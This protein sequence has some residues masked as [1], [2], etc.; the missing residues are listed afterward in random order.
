MNTS[1]RNLRFDSDR[2]GSII[3][4]VVMVLAV[5]AF[6]TLAYF[7]VTTRSS[8]KK[9]VNI[10]LVAN[11]NTNT[12]PTAVV[13]TNTA[14]AVNTNITAV[15]TNSS[16][17]NDATKSWKTFTDKKFGYSFRY[18][19]SISFADVAEGAQ[20]IYG[21]YE[22]GGSGQITT[23]GTLTLELTVYDHRLGQLL[24]LNE[25]DKLKQP[26]TLKMTSGTASWGVIDGA[27]GQARSELQFLGQE[28]DLIITFTEWGTSTPIV[29]AEIFSSFNIPD[30]PTTTASYRLSCAADP[31]TGSAL[32]QQSWWKK[33][34]S[35][36][37]TGWTL[38]EACLNA[39]L[40]QVV[41]EKSSTG[42][43]GNGQS[44][45]GVYD[46]AS[47]TFVKATARRAIYGGECAGHTSWDIKTGIIAY[48]CGSGDAGAYWY[49]E[50]TFNP[51]TQANTKIRECSGDAETNKETCS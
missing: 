23:P 42:G 3:P 47:D 30:R 20:Y 28:Q 9:N 1:I 24:R 45:I 22:P 26:Q 46:I 32:A 34:A 10:A 13:H 49:G 8:T 41:Y 39:E 14:S 19:A 21:S 29:A 11:S 16:A 40:Q 50:Y 25:Y 2:E 17:T 18:P 44:L 35:Q 38:D 4:I 7:A 27:D 43:Q 51:K 12:N 31:F 37:I 36:I 15:N 48:R 5:A 6:S 33:F